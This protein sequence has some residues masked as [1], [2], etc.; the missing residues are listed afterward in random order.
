MRGEDSDSVETSSPSAAGE[1]RSGRGAVR[2]PG[3]EDRRSRAA[4]RVGSTPTRSLSSAATPFEVRRPPDL[5]GVEAIV[6]PGGESTTLSMLLE[7][8]ELFEPLAERLAAGMPALGTCAGMILLGTEVLDGRP[9]QRIFGAI[10]LTVRRNAFGR[11][12]DSF[13]A[14]LEIDGHG[15]GAFHAVFIRAPYVE[16]VGDGVEVLAEVDGP[17]GAVPPGPGN[18]CPRSTRSWPAICGSINAFSGGM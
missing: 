6:L 17:S 15:G 8:S 18:W 1:T 14:D 2:P 12:V 5:A 4:G 9:D 3:A 13:E 11:Q 16:R 7:S 10:D